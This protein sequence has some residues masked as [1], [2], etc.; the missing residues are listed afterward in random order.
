MRRVLKR[1][2][3]VPLGL[4]IGL[5]AVELVLQVLSFAARSVVGR[6]LPTGWLTGSVRV[7]CLGDSNT[8]GLYVERDEAYPARLE[9]LWNERI[10]SPRL[11]VLN[12]GVPGTSSSSLLRDYP[13]RLATFDPDVVLVL[14][15]ANDFWTLP[16]PVREEEP[17]ASWLDALRRRSRLYRYFYMIR[18]GR[19][20]SQVE[21]RLTREDEQGKRYE[22]RVGDRRFDSEWTRK[23]SYDVEADA[24]ALETNLASL[25]ERSRIRGVALYV[26]TYPSGRVPYVQANRVI[27]ETPLREPGRGIDLHR[28]F[29]SRCETPD[30]PELLFEDGHPNAAGY[31]LVAETIVEVL[32]R[33]RPFP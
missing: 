14:V 17:G 22:L 7:L 15:G 28:A 2:L 12:L 6:G 13:V 3:L 11:E 32:E 24:L 20:A 9:A 30:C 26:M 19:E 33:D 31:R 25:V 8:Y 4:A 5:L 27:E 1:L 18:R 23:S 16:V 29:E 21:V 10:A